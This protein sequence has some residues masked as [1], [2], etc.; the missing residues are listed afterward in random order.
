MVVVVEVV[1]LPAIEVLEED[2]RRGERGLR[3]SWLSL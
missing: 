2:G 1:L 3:D